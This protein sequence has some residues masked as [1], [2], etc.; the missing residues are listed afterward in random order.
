LADRGGVYL[1]S[2]GVSDAVAPYADDAGHAAELWDLSEK[3][4]AAA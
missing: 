3:L 4:C 1:E 2:C